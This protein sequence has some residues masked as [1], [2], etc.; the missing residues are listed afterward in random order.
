MTYLRPM[1]ALPCSWS[2]SQLAERMLLAAHQLCP[3]DPATCHELGCL[4]YRNGQYAAATTWLRAALSLVPAEH[5]QAQQDVQ[6]NC[7]ASSL[8]SVA[9][10]VQLGG[11]LSN[12]WEPTVL[13][14]GHCMRKQWKWAEALQ[15]R[16]CRL[17]Y[18][19]GHRVRMCLQACLQAS[20]KGIGAPCCTVVQGSA[21]KGKVCLLCGCG[22]GWMWVDLD[23]LF[24]GRSDFLE[25]V[26]ASSCKIRELLVQTYVQITEFGP[27]CRNVTC[28]FWTPRV[29]PDKN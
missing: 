4:N 9:A 25:I 3:A 17:W 5:R 20:I 29:K 10:V 16:V 18:I 1:C 15:V 22:Y 14:L 8:G 12:A 23:S 7:S 27:F 11:R 6:G 21:F 24:Q 2:C 28:N 26:F 19:N 13:A